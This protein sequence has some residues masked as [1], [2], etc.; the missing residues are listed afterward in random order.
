MKVPAGP[1]ITV[2]LRLPWELKEAIDAVAV[3]SRR[4]RSQQMLVFL[5]EGASRCGQPAAQATENKT[6]A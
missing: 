3:A 4:S 6:A 2:T 1:G 5:E